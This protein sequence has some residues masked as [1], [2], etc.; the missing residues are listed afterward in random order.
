[1]N[2]LE[3]ILKLVEDIKQSDLVDEI[4]E[5]IV[6]TD[7]VNESNPY[8][9]IFLSTYSPLTLEESLELKDRFIDLNSNFNFEFGQ[10]NEYNGAC[11]SVWKS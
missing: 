2:K 4:K 3:E 6:Y 1:M 7:T 5:V 9:K 11:L 10:F 8:P